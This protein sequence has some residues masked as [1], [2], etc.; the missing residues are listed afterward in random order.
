VSF[1]IDSLRSATP[2]CVRRRR[3]LSSPRSKHKHTFSP[4]VLLLVSPLCSHPFTSLPHDVVELVARQSPATDDRRW[5]FAPPPRTA[6]YDYAHVF[7]STDCF[8]TDIMC[9][10]AYTADY[11]FC[12]C[13]WFSSFLYF[14]LTIPFRPMIFDSYR[15]DLR[16]IFRVGRTIAVDDQSEISFSIPHG[17]LPWQPIFVS[18]IRR[19]K[20][21]WHSV[22]GVSVC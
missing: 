18:F 20:F 3:N 19:T 16:Q 4:A 2:Q 7:N 1:G 13:F 11:M 22:D 8:S 15:T 12:W 9:T 6:D 10:S 14:C 17:T 21:R 5:T